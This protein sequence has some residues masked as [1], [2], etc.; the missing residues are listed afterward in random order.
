M[1]GIFGERGLTGRGRCGPSNS[2]SEVYR[3]GVGLVP[4][5]RREK[6]QSP[7]VLACESG[8]EGCL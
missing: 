2:R 4:D 1:E 6:S 5:D 3:E 8:T 7:W